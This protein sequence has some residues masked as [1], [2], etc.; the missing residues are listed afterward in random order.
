MK[1]LGLILDGRWSFGQHFVH[2]GPRLINA[3]A[4]LGRLLPNVG[5]PGSLCRRLYSGVVRS[6][7]LYGAPIW[8]DAL[9]AD[10]RALLR[11]PQRVIAV[12][13]IRGYRTVSWAAATLLAGDPPWELQAEV[14]A[15]RMGAL[16]D[17]DSVS[18]RMTVDMAVEVGAPMARAE[19]NDLGLNEGLAARPVRLSESDSS[20]CSMMTVESGD[21]TPK[22]M[23]QKRQK[24]A[25]RTHA[26][27]SCSGSESDAS[28]QLGDNSESSVSRWLKPATKRGRGRPPTHG[29]YVGIGK[30]QEELREAKSKAK[31][32]RF[33]T[34]DALA[35]YN[36]TAKLALEERAARRANRQ[37]DEHA[38]DAPKTSAA[39][40]TTVQQAL[41]V[42]LQVAD[43]SGNLK[44]TFVR[45]LKTAADTIKGAVAEL[46]ALTMSEEVARLE[47]A[48][49]QLSG[50][51]AELRREVAEMRR[52]PQDNNEEGLK[53]IMEEA[54][55]SSRE[56]FGNMLNARMEGI[57]RRLLPEPRLR[58]PLAADRKE[59][60]AAASSNTARVSAPVEPPT[61]KVVEKA[62][63]KPKKKTKRPSMAAK[64]AA[65][66]AAK[67]TAPPPAPKP[68]GS[69]ASWAAVVRQ[70]PNKPPKKPKAPE[71]KSKER[72]PGRKLRSPRT[73]VITITLKPGAEEKGVRYEDVLAEAKS[74]IKLGEVGLTSVRFRTTATGARMLEVPPGTNDAEKAADA[75]AVKLR[76]VLSSDAVQVHRP[77]KCVELRILDLDDSV[78]AVE[79][80]SAVAEEGGCSAGAIK[81]GVIA[82]R[83]GGSGSLWMSCP[84]AAAK[85]VLEVGRVK[86]GWVSARVRLLEPR[87]LRC[88]RCLEG[89]HM[90]AKC[91]R[92]V[93]RSRLCFRCGLPDHRARECTAAEANCIVC[94]AAG[95]PAAHAVGS[96]ACQGS[97]T[98]LA[99]KKGG[100]VAKGPV[101]ASQRTVEEPMETAQ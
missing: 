96:K 87:P 85:R 101:T 76:E 60:E 39:L 51:L 3:A 23:T 47:A 71:K 28:V 68:G 2:L 57:E 41:D 58:P 74:R 21:D 16:S 54:L 93:D 37:T 30:S 97:K 84:V 78:T 24:G 48:N 75:L 10:N 20:V 70:Q 95:K 26:E 6:M 77:T 25:K 69:G 42:V 15:E 64:E 19:T 14:L 99:S 35:V 11:K 73:A 27:E 90:G 31:T 1:Y 92:G 49:A 5:G 72:R 62:D 22:E 91:D 34:E 56:Q 32:D 94:S 63:K 80:V 55:R 44:G 29:R 33:Q 59:A 98:R 36:E 45:A 67:K 46:R 83:S 66:A 17:T 7:A 52:K 82:R 81:P 65:A 4:A 13:G 43:K 89:G 38:E 40:D 88:F 61:A 9:T 86:V 100:A 12:R 53:R 50:Q 79:V 8:V 18:S